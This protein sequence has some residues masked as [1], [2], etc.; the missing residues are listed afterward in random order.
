M[1][2]DLIQRVSR[3]AQVLDQVVVDGLAVVRAAQVHHQ[4]AVLLESVD[5]VEGGAGLGVV[6]HCTDLGQRTKH[7]IGDNLN[8]GGGGADRRGCSSPR[9][10]AC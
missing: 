1:G 2:G 4:E 8:D 3:L 10:C 6:L 7:E 5:L 9:L